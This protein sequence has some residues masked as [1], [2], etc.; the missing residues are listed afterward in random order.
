MKAIAG[1]YFSQIKLAKKIEPS[2][3]TIFKEQRNGAIIC[4]Q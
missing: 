3:G 2:L 1:K 4:Y